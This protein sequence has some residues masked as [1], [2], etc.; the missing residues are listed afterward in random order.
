MRCN[1]VITLSSLLCTIVV[2]SQSCCYCDG[3]SSREIT[4]LHRYYSIIRLPKLLQLSLLYYRLFNL[5]SFLERH[6]RIS[7][8]A[9]L[10][11]YPAC[12]ASPKEPT[13]FV[14]PTFGGT[15]PKQP[16]GTCLMLHQMLVSR[17]GTLSP[18]LLESYEAKS[19]L[20]FPAFEYNNYSSN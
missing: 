20:Y 3:L 19:S 2:S 18:C 6:L 7:R 11:C 16:D 10:S 8:V 15:T 14:K 5:L 17:R 12:H 4:L 13:V 9:N 1:F